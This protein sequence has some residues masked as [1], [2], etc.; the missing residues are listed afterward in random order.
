MTQTKKY[1]YYKNRSVPNVTLR[2]YQLHVNSK[3]PVKE[4]IWP[5]ESP[6]DLKMSQC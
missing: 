2:I 4:E 6:T 3:N 1:L 5:L